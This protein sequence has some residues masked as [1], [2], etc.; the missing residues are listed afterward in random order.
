MSRSFDIRILWYF[1]KSPSST[2][3]FLTILAVALALVGF[4]KEDGLVL[5]I[6]GVGFFLINL[7][8][9]FRGWFTHVKGCEVDDSAKRFMDNLNL[10]QCVINSLEIAPEM[11]EEIEYSVLHGYCCVGIETQPL[12]RWDE[13]DQQARSSNYQLTYFGL[14]R[15]VLFAYTTVKSLV[16]AEFS[17]TSHIWKIA[18][19]AS[20]EV[21]DM[22]RDCKIDAKKNS[23]V[24]KAEFPVLLVNCENGD[25]FIFA[26]R[27]EQTE[28]A[29]RVVRHV[30]E[31][32]GK[33]NKMRMPGKKSSMAKFSLKWEDL[34]KKQK[35]ALQIGIIGDVLGTIK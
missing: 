29:Y 12:F 35:K 14:D 10:K 27:R 4:I 26:F 5:I 7:W 30:S 13:E 6:L 16:D 2:T 32:K 11:L 20:V 21:H 33:A 15:E 1:F 24:R 23:E 3:F 31:L 25:E 17:E 34:S 8:Q 18:D 19:L 22:I 9:L 28:A